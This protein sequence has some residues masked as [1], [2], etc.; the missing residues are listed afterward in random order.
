MNFTLDDVISAVREKAESNPRTTYCGDGDKCDYTRG[1]CSNGAVGCLFGQVLAELGVPVANLKRHDDAGGLDIGNV[2][3]KM[4]IV[5]DACE[6]EWCIH[7]QQHQ[8]MGEP[9][10]ECIEWA[11]SFERLEQ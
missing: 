1:R 9:W 11:D 6:A 4:G 7:V 5:M 8:D 3:E 2:L 10:A